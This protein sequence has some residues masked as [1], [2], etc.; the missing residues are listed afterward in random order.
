M[1]PPSLYL[2][3]GVIQCSLM[4]LPMFLTMSSIVFAPSFAPLRS[5]LF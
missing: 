1:A 2:S 5:H 4:S 3:A